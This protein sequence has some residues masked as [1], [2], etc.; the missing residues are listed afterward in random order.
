MNDLQRTG[1]AGTRAIALRMRELEKGPPKEFTARTRAEAMSDHMHALYRYARGYDQMP[2]PTREDASAIHEM[3]YLLLDENERLRREV[4]A[5]RMYERM[6]AF[7]GR[8]PAL[9]R[10]RRLVLDS[11]RATPLV[12]AAA[13]ELTAL[14]EELEGNAL[15]AEFARQYAA[16]AIAAAKSKAP[17]GE[18][19]A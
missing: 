13:W 16:E 18:V 5:E 9:D 6:A 19:A 8:C 4:G 17:R 12:Q 11:T 10:W 7:T 2:E 1:E 3:Y 14:L 15:D